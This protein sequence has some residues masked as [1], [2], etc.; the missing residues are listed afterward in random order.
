MSIGHILLNVPMGDMIRE[1]AFAIA[2]S[3]VKLDESSIDVA[4]MMGGLRTVYNEEGTVSFEDSRVFFGHEYVKKEDAK[5]AVIAQGL[6]DDDSDATKL[7][8]KLPTIGKEVR[9]PTR[10]SMLE[11][12]F[13]PVFYHFVDTIIEVK[14]SISITRTREFTRTRTNTNNN[15]SYRKNG[16]FGGLFGRRHKR[17]SVSTSQV[18]ASYSSKYSYSAEGSSLIRTKLAPVP[19]PPILEERIHDLME[20]EEARRNPP[21]TLPSTPP[22]T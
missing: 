3:Q 2:E 18:N 5:S 17:S 10:V 21:A 9:V 14:I 12:G 1:M 8:D 4:E 7:V 20:E 6:A 22:S 19:P 16:L 15:S 11:L 13:A